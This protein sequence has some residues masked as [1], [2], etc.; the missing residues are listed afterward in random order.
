MTKPEAKF[1]RARR[2]L[3]DFEL[4]PSSFI[5]VG[6]LCGASGC[7]CVSLGPEECMKLWFILPVALL[8]AGCSQPHHMAVSNPAPATSSPP[9]ITSAQSPMTD[10]IVKTDEEWKK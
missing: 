2:L 8:V 7:L 5:L 4:L 10:K 6:A 9:A 3:S 1:S